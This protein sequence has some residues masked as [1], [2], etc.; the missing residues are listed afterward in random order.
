MVLPAP[1]NVPASRI[2]STGTGLVIAAT[3]VR[4][5]SM[6]S[7]AVVSATARAEKARVKRE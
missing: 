7:I 4:L 5:V 3:A 6:A 2:L 1:G